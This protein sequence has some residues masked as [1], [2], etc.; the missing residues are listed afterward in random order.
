MSP[1]RPEPAATALSSFELAQLEERPAS[2]VLL[3]IG[4]AVALHLL[5]FALPLPSMP[6]QEP[7]EVAKAHPIVLRTIVLEPPPPTKRQVIKRRL[8]RKLPIPDP[9]PHT[10]EPIVE[11]APIAPGSSWNSPGG[12]RGAWRRR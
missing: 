8:T 12:W 4:L 11:S 10:P 5:V 9:S 1:H 2:H 3:C 7:I 6:D